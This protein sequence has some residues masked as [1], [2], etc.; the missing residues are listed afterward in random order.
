M[1]R[2]TWHEMYESVVRQA[3]ALGHSRETA[4]LHAG[5]FVR[6]M[7]WLEMGAAHHAQVM[8]RPMPPYP[9]SPLK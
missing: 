3:M 9:A 7:V 5:A 8:G 4:E 2:Q 6:Y 1:R